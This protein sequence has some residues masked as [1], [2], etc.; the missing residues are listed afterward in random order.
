VTWG[1]LLVETR[2]LPTATELTVKAYPLDGCG[3]PR[4]GEP[5]RGR[6]LVRRQGYLEPLDYHAGRPV[7]VT[8]RLA[9]SAETRIGETPLILPLLDEAVVQ[10]WPDPTRPARG[11]PGPLSR[12]AIS[13]G[14]GGGSGHVGGGIGIGF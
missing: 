9:A 3:R 11:W 6:F 13:I 14:I 7:T 12:P 4:T 2:N 5:P 10:L 1:G 8:G